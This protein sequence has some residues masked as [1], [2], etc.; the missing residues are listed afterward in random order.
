[1]QLDHLTK[2]YLAL[3]PTTRKVVRVNMSEVIIKK[4]DKK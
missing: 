2:F 3:K 4:I 1:M